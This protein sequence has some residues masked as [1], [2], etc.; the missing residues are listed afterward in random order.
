[1]KTAII[2]ITENGRKLSA[3]TAELLEEH[4]TERYCYEKHSDPNAQPFA[5]L[6]TLTGELFGKNEAIVFIC[7]C[8]IAV[9][10]IAPFLNNKQD[11][12]AVIVIDDCGKFVIP[13]LSGHLGGANALAEII[14]ERLHAQCAITTATDIC[15]RFSPD[16]FAAANGLIITDMSAAKEIAAAVLDNEKIGFVTDMAYGTL[17][18][19]LAEST[20]CRTGITV[21]ADTDYKPF[22]VTLTLV[23]RNVILGIGCRRGTTEAE[24]TEA[25]YNT[26]YDAGIDTGRICAV[27]TIDIKGDEK[28]LLSFCGSRDIPIMTY[29]AQELSQVQG[30]FTG[31]DFV[32][33]VTGVDNVCE[34]SAVLCSGK[35]LIMRK[36]SL[37]GVTVAA[38]ERDIYLDFER[39][40]I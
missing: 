16:S 17:P 35:G 12:P 24:I 32:R 7:A 18:P 28:G 29:S 27:A 11:D 10:M 1:M 25:V 23:P 21:T 22:P 4:D 34:R 5:E 8:G 20:Q 13:I 33:S 26:F 19:E 38:A 9:R 6:S 39:K 3:K 14:A 40:M 2:S 31:S 37:N 30:D 36:T 15:G